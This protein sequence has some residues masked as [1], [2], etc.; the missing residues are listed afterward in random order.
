MDICS[1][2]AMF[3]ITGVKAYNRLSIDDCAKDG[4]EEFSTG[5]H[6]VLKSIDLVSVESLKICNSNTMHLGKKFLA[7]N[8]SATLYRPYIYSENESGSNDIS[9]HFVEFS[10]HCDRSSNATQSNLAYKIL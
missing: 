4:G 8:F 5:M 3:Y 10:N 1:F 9:L 2:P 6:C 7:A